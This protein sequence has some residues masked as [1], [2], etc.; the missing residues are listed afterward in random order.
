VPPAPTAPRPAG[1]QASNRPAK[2]IEGTL[3][4]HG[5]ARYHFDSNQPLSYVA[6]IK[7]SE[8]ERMVWGVGLREA[9]QQSR[10]RVDIGDEV[11]LQRI[12]K[13]PVEVMVEKRDSFGNEKMEKVVRQRAIWRVESR[14][15]HATRD[16]ADEAASDLPGSPRP[17]RS[18]RSAP[19]SIAAL[20]DTRLAMRAAELLAADRLKDPE[21]RRRFVDA[22]AARF[23]EEL[24]KGH[25]IPQP[26]LRPRAPTAERAAEMTR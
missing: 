20:S 3:L 16:Q 17:P 9:I 7:T 25:A 4:S 22:V 15:W 1:A 8:G 26:Q 11:V 18:D 2:A 10:S 21:D 6:K 14:A 23:A 13:K 5:V 24:A 12:G 19:Q